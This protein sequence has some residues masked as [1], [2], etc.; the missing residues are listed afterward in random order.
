MK[1]MM[2]TVAALLGAVELVDAHGY[3]SDPL[4]RM[5]RSE[6][7]E[8]EG[9]GRTKWAAIVGENSGY[10]DGSAPNMNA[11]IPGGK[12]GIQIESTRGHGLRGDNGRRKALM[13]SG[14][15]GPTSFSAGSYQTGGLL[16]ATVKIT[17]YHSGWFEFRLC[18]VSTTGTG[19][20]TQECLDSILR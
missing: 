20:V 14:Q 10:G 9:I 13:Q 6:G 1:T 11:A 19:D 3:L 2:L 5:Y 16:P 18:D 12:V 7:L 8:S 17:A 4:P 15:Y